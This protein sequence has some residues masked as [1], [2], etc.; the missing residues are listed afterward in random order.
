MRIV[1][2]P[3]IIQGSS[4]TQCKALPTISFVAKVYTAHLTTVV[5][6]PASCTTLVRVSVLGGNNILDD[7]GELLSQ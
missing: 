1:H 2:L 4:G 6:P 5:I 3:I 7:C